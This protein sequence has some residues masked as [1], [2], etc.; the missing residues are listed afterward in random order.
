MSVLLVFLVEELSM[1]AFLKELLPRAFPELRFRCIPHDGKKDLEKSLPRKLRAW[2]EP[3]VRFVVVRDQDAEECR[4]LK[5]RL[6][7]VCRDA[8]REDSLVRIACRELEA[9]Y[10]GDLEAAATAL[11]QPR[12]R[13]LAGKAWLRDPDTVDRPSFRLRE[14]APGA[15]SKIE[16][17]RRIG[18]RLDPSKNT[19]RSFRAFLDGVARLIRHHERSQA[20]AGRAL[21]LVIR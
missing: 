5:R 19:S 8:G 3:G 15:A 2:R 18:A 10:L 20:C 16:C 17:A 11:N 4:E 9:W 6:A 7:A 21:R 14:L 12:L 1:E 13:E